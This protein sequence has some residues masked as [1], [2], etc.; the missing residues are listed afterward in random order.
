MN[1]ILPRRPVVGFG[2][3]S[4]VSPPAGGGAAAGRDDYGYDNEYAVF[5]GHAHLSHISLRSISHSHTV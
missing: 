2:G 3:S 1:V 4:P 5:D